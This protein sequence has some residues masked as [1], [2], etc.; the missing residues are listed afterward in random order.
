MVTRAWESV[1]TQQI[2]HNTVAGGGGVYP[3]SRDYA[4]S[5]QSLQRL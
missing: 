4:P 1:T 3:G 5:I 2:A